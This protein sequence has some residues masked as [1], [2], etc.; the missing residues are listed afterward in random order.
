MYYPHTMTLLTTDTC[1][2]RCSHCSVYS[3][4]D[5]KDKLTSEQMIAA[6]DKVHSLGKLSTVVFAGGEPTLLKHHLL[7]A[8]A[9]VHSLNLN[10]RLVTNCSWA[11]SNA[12]AKQKLVEFREAGLWE[13][14][15]SLDDFHSPY[16]PIQ[17]ALYAW[18]ESKNLGFVSVIIATS[19]SSA[20][21]LTPEKI[22]DLLGEDVPIVDHDER[23]EFRSLVAAEDGTKYAISSGLLQNLGRSH[24]ELGSE[25][26]N[27]YRLNQ[28]EGGCQMMANSCAVS[29]RNTLLSC[30]GFEVSGNSILDFGSLDRTSASELLEE[31]SLDPLPVAISRLGP[32]HLASIAVEI[33]KD[34][35]V[36]DKYTSVCSLCEHVMTEPKIRSALEENRG[37]VSLELL[38]HGTNIDQLGHL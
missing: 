19:R 14:N 29:P 11:T 36:R 3:S 6:I 23:E 32:A 24:D 20:T 4:P 7:D 2:A 8:I 10:T 18:H 16:I 13:L 35:G 17:S 34:C 9:H 28:L 27:W 22:R 26:F 25:Y 21:V 12:K 15:I 38:M 33:D 5:R 37:R 1:T 31:A 30:C